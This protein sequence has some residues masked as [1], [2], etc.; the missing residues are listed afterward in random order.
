MFI[1][2]TPPS[3]PLP[4]LSQYIQYKILPR[5]VPSAF[6]LLWFPKNVSSYHYTKPR[7]RL[8][9][10]LPEAKRSS[11]SHQQNVMYASARDMKV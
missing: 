10:Y 9:L 4:S 7:A 5:N 3:L 6:P 2:S 11:P 8:R 1:S